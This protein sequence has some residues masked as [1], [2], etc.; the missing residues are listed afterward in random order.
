MDAI[1]RF[2]MIFAGLL[3]A[4]AVA[5]VSIPFLAFVDPLVREA[6][7]WVVM[8]KLLA[9]FGGPPGPAN[10]I[11]LLMEL[12]RASTLAICIT[13]VA[14]AALIG[15]L[16]EEAEARLAQMGPQQPDLFGG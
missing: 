11:G 12:M 9:V 16:R 4:A 5:A 10:A 8:G 15:E 14:L 3:C 6:I 13:P 1:S 2:L 7:I